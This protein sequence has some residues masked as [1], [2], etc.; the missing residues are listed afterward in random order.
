MWGG[1]GE[2]L[3]EG[4][5]GQT[6]LLLGLDIQW[7]KF[8]RTFEKLVHGSRK[9]L[10]LG[11]VGAIPAGCLPSPI[12]EGSWAA[13]R[14]SRGGVAAMK[15]FAFWSPHVMSSKRSAEQKQEQRQQPC[16]PAGQSAW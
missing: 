15:H 6:S 3:G 2:G 5:L 8:T 12:L 10:F 14:A 1:A 13:P 16:S 4:N 9:T 11:W 7:P